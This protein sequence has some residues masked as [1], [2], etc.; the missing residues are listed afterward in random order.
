MFR[1]GVTTCAAR[2]AHSS[3]QSQFT[4][5]N[6]YTLQWSQKPTIWIFPR[7]FARLDC[8]LTE[9]VIPSG[10][11]EE[12]RAFSNGREGNMAP[13]SSVSV[14]CLVLP[15]IILQ[16]KSDLLLRGFFC[17]STCTG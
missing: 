3:N 16:R 11:R 12:L 7:L 2:P 15:V 6:G 9:F 8:G 4:G 5:E 13:V 10:Q 14:P 17:G 1:R